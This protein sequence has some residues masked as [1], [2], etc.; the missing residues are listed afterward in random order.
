MW[1]PIMLLLA[2]MMSA[3][4]SGPAAA[5]TTISILDV[6]DSG[7]TVDGTTFVGDPNPTLPSTGTGVFEPF[8]RTQTST[9]HGSGLEHGFNTDAKQSDINFDTKSGT[10]THSVQ[11]GELGILDG[12]YWLSLDADQLGCATC[13]E[14]QIRITDMQIYIG[15]DSNLANPA[16]TNTGVNG[17]GYTG[18]PFNNPYDAT[19]GGSSGLLGIAP[20]WTLD[21][22]TNGDVTIILQASICDSSGECG[23]GHG[24]L[25][26]LIPQNRLSG[27]STDY[28]VL[29]VE[30]SSGN[31]GPEEWKI[32][33]AQTPTQ[34]PEPAS[35][36]LVASGLIT[37]VAW[38]AV[39]RGRAARSV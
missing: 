2:L 18:T 3:F 22:A 26:V 15:S 38:A 1:I 35:L 14:N 10:W 5:V 39:K 17:T 31:D 24:D 6:G 25:G 32:Y 36:A 7:T 20:I 19:P 34:V 4:P 30:Y 21:S 37:G 33:D 28:F 9:G 23:S 8:V 16:A 12:Y 13:V 29:Y 11:F 27:A